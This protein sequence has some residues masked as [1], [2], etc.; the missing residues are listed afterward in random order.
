MTN[1]GPADLREL[2]L[3]LASELILLAGLAPDKPAA[4]AL[5]KEQISNGTALAKLRQ[6]IT[7]QGG[8]T[9][10]SRLPKADLVLPYKAKTGGYLAAIDARK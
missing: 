3:A 9:D 8:D 4:M 6:M 5:V 10:F 1:R 2:S 7:C